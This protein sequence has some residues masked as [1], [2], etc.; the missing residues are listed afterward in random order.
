[1]PDRAAAIGEL[2]LR[3]HVGPTRWRE[4]RH[5][6]ALKE[7]VR[8]RMRHPPDSPSARR[9]ILP[10]QGGGGYR[11]NAWDFTAGKKF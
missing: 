8:Q 1:M 2:E 4:I 10:G 7:R 11:M 6:S 9:F 5:N 3:L